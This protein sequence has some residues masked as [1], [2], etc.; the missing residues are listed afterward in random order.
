MKE[1]K[2]I[3]LEAIRKQY[4]W[5]TEDWMLSDLHQ[6]VKNPPFLVKIINARE[7]LS[8][9]VHPGNEYAWEKENSIGKTEMWYVL[10]CDP[11]AYLYY[12]LKHK[13][14]S[15]EFMKRVKNDT[16]LEVCKKI[17]VKK[18]DVFFIP[19]GLIHAIGKGIKVAEIQQNS[20][21]TYRVYDYH[22][23]DKENNYRP[24]HIN[25]AKDVMG[26]LPPLQ[27]HRPMGQRKLKDGYYKTLLVQCPYFQVNRIEV[28]REWKENARE[29]DQSLLIVEGSGILYY[30]KEKLEVKAGDSI[31][32]KKEIGN[33]QVEGRLQI[34]LSKVEKRGAKA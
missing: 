25:Q 27:G 28:E 4:L 16:L 23:R 15:N 26:F 18:G 2:P 31:F 5:G 19:A 8:I 7:N 9:Q 14:S 20:N 11:G 21:I 12:G 6:E 3:K 17:S 13:I 24:L 32:L 34:L 22:R 10:E 1:V 33:Y 30:N 29:G